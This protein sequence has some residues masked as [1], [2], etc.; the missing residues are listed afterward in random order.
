MTLKDYLVKKKLTHKK[1]AQKIDV[2]T[3]QMSRLVNGIHMP[4]LKTAYKIYLATGKQV[5]L[6]DWFSNEG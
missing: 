2:D 4:S 6:Q 3:A 1:L 5:K